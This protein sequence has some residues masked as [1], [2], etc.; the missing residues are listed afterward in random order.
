[1]PL[2]AC[3]KSGITSSSTSS[4]KADRLVK[5]SSRIQMGSSFM[6]Q[7]IL[8]R[9]QLL[10]SVPFVGWEAMPTGNTIWEMGWLEE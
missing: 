9:N 7:N 6:Q 3:S 10:I 8:K 1:M 2:D 4:H 5:G